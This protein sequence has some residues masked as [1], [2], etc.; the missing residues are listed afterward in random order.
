MVLNIPY[1]ILHYGHSQSVLLLPSGGANKVCLDRF[2]TERTK[3][4]ADK[5][6]V[7]IVQG[8]RAA[9]GTGKTTLVVSWG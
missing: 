4:T 2:T 9:D 6:A 1:V 8:Y 3:V 7:N 5:I